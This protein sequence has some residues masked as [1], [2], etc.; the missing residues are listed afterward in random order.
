L[1]EV[2]VVAEAAAIEGTAILATGFGDDRRRLR[3]LS[4][5]AVRYRGSWFPVNTYVLCIEEGS[6]G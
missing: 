5:L 1:V 4:G 2:V 3:N 6:C